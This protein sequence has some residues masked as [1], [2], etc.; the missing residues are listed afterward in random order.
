MIKTIQNGEYTL[1]ETKGH[2]KIL[3]LDRKATFAWI[4]AQN[5]GEIL[6]A[7]HNPHK[8]DHTLAIGKYRIYEVKNEPNITD[9]IHL[10]L[11]IGEGKWQG[12]LLL[13]GLPKGQKKRNRI[14]P[15]DE[16]ITHVTA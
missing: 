7:S 2:V 13:N 8:A 12:Y 16:I 3:T 9:L 6:V 10:E 1:L 5:I 4:N 14:I 15:T 11:M